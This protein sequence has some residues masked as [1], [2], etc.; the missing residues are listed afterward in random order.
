MYPEDFSL[1][2]KLDNVSGASSERASRITGES[3]EAGAK[4]EPAWQ[5]SSVNIEASSP[6]F[7]DG[8]L[9]PTGEKREE[10][11][12][13]RRISAFS[14]T[15]HFRSEESPRSTSNSKFRGRKR[16][17]SSSPKKLSKTAAKKHRD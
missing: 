16:P 8:R 3:I 10:E 13:A 6:E 12:R 17:S 11:I 4:G 15:S 5:R 14:F 9:I 2:E 7:P 1:K